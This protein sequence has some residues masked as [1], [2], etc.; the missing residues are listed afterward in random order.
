MPST[1]IDLSWNKIARIHDLDDVAKILF[2]NNKLHQKTFLAVYVE[3]KWARNHFIP[4]LEMLADR[5]GVSR[6]TL[7]TVRAK[8]RRMGLI[9]HISRFNQKYGYREGW[10]ISQ[11][12]CRTTRLLADLIEDFRER[13]GNR[14]EAKDRRL[15]DYL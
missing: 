15:L 4:T 11:K 14:Q 1:K 3:L 10:I 9:D 12:F 7:E 8:M 2:P 6:R 13:R 5:N